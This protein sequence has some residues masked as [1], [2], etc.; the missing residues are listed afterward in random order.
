MIF[1]A[2]IFDPEIHLYSISKPGFEQTDKLRYNITLA[3]TRF[4]EKGISYKRVCED[5]SVFSVGFAKQTLL[6]ADQIKADLITV[7]ATPTRENYYF[8]DSD[9]EAIITN[10]H[11]IPVLCASGTKHEI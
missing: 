4:S 6:Y 1:M 11:C 10:E 2:G 7:M 3:E 8:A 5:Q 9:K